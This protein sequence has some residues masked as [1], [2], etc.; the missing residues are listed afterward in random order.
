MES[1][2]DEDAS[3][4][5]ASNARK[6]A[7]VRFSLAAIMFVLTAASLILG[8]ARVIPL[9]EE[10]RRVLL[11]FGLVWGVIG[12]VAA[13]PATLRFFE[14]RRQIQQRNEKLSAWVK[15]KQRAVKKD[16]ESA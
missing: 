13:G 4:N 16:G 14:L 2:E 1:P 6:P 8:V 9:P 5:V 12:L 7:R 10:L 11:I 3:L 15:A